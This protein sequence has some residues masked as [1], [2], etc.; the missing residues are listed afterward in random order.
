MT[1][2]RKYIIAAIVVVP[3]MLALPFFR[4]RVGSLAVEI[5]FIEP[6]RKYNRE[7]MDYSVSIY[8]DGSVWVTTKLTAINPECTVHSSRKVW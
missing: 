8:Y 1:R 5:G 3:I 7:Y 4:V 2:R 6:F